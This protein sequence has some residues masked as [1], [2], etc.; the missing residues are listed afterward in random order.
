MLFWLNDRWIDTSFSRVSSVFMSKSKHN[1]Q[2]TDLMF[3]VIEPYVNGISILRPRNCASQTGIIQNEGEWWRVSLFSA[4]CVTSQHIQNASQ[5]SL[6]SASRVSFIVILCSKNRSKLCGK[7][8]GQRKTDLPA[9]HAIVVC[10]LASFSASCQFTSVTP[11][12][13]PASSDASLAGKKLLQTLAHSWIFLRNRG[14]TCVYAYI[15]TYTYIHIYIYIYT[16]VDVRVKMLRCTFIC[17]SGSGIASW[18]RNRIDT[19]TGVE[20]KTHCRKEDTL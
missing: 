8:K 13:P 6:S 17:R 3:L 7:K 5:V 12:P 15:Y 10:R 14:D 1:K 2:P 19:C 20:R 4:T 18:L 11:H 16:H 9:G